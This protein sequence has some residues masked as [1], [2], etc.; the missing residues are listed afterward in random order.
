MNF[1]KLA[2]SA[3]AVLLAFGLAFPAPALAT[4]ENETETATE[5]ETAAALESGVEGMPAVGSEEAA[6]ANGETAGDEDAAA[7][8]DADDAT[9][10]DLEAEL[11]AGGSIKVYSVSGSTR[12]DTAVAA[13]KKAYPDGV[14]SQTAIVVCGGDDSWADSL[15]A[16][17]LAGLVDCPILYTD[18]YYLPD[19]TSQALGQLGVSN[20]LVVGG[21]G[22]VSDDVV[23][24]LSG[25]CS[26]VQRIAGSSRYETQL[27]VYEYGA[28]VGTWSSS[29]I[30]ASGSS[31]AD[32]LS[33]SPIAF[34]KKMP[35]FL[36]APD[37][38]LTY[39]QVEA[40]LDSESG[41]TSFMIAGG[42]SAVSSTMDSF[43]AG[44]LVK[45][46]GSYDTSKVERLAGGDRYDT[47]WQVASWGASNG[48]LGWDQAGFASGSKAADALA[49]CVLQ[50]KRSAPMLL[51]GDDLWT[52]GQLASHSPS[53]V[54]VYGGTAVVSATAR[55]GIAKKLGYGLTQIEGF[56]VYVDAGHGYN[57]TGTGAWDS[58]ACG[59]GYQEANLT[60]E[61]AQKVASRLRADG[62]DVFLND[63]GGPYKYRHGEAVANDCNVI[64]SIHFNA[65]GGSGSMSLVHEYNACEYSWSV[66]QT[67]HPYL[68][69]GTGLHDY[70]IRGQEVAILGGQLPAVLLE[71]AFID[72]SSDMNAYQS[73]KDTVAEKIA[74]GIEAL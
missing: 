26:S 54:S 52:A 19:A 43:L 45:S 63:D 59:C 50:G 42:T 49:G 12:Y 41:V 51:L 70:G 25:I 61:L 37:E 17:S 3:L 46:T 60:A 58:G 53:S 16:S 1:K 48:Y 24:S 64:V 22:V 57:N 4:V 69:A 65:G 62:V 28:D 55:N 44:V 74:T 39:S 7:A 15:S 5:E 31:F 23:S 56:K 30:V 47:S 21:D 71:V 9:L 18:T 67:L 68:V 34:S 20:V 36:S 10:D 38:N 66:A 2:N 27:A 6:A 35:I 33:A 73:R 72:N 11:A 8:A 29:V 13:A 14:A 32:A 40:L